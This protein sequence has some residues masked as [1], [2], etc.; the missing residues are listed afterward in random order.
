[1]RLTEQ[2]LLVRPSIIPTAIATTVSM[3]VAFLMTMNR[4]CYLL[5]NND[6]GRHELL[7]R[8]LNR[9]SISRHRSCGAEEPI[10][11]VWKK[12]SLFYRVR[13]VRFPGQH[14]LKTMKPRFRTCSQNDDEVNRNLR[15]W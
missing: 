14:Y 3:S 15:H 6:L 11:W 12:E 13:Q 8:M 9:F 7:T 4:Y 10:S 2:S 5:K 1:M